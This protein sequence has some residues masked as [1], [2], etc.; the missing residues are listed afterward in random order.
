MVSR[1]IDYMRSKCTISPQTAFVMSSHNIPGLKPFNLSLQEEGPEISILP[2]IRQ[3]CLRASSANFNILKTPVQIQRTFLLQ[4]WTDTN[5]NSWLQ[6][7]LLYD[8]P[9]PF[10]RCESEY[11]LCAFIDLGYYSTMKLSTCGLP[12]RIFSSI[13]R[14]EPHGPQVK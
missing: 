6:T 9:Y 5:Q 10:H 14:K 4:V 11:R 13:P 1:T 2:T 7:C 12:M 8:F 3:L